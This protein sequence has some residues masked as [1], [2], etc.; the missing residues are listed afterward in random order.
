[1]SR[2][3][4][5]ARQLLSEA[6]ITLNGDQPHDIQIHNESCLRKII[7]G[8]SLALGETYMDGDWDSEQLDTTMTRIMSARL[9]EKVSK[10][11]HLPLLLKTFLINPQSKERAFI[12]GEEHYDIGNDVYECMLDENMVYTCAYW[13]NSVDLSAAQLAKLDL[14]CQKIGLKSGDHVLDIGC[15]WGSFAHYAASRY[16]AKVTGVTVSK[17]QMRLAQ[18]RCAGLDVHFVLQDYRDIQGH[19]VFDH[20]VSLGMFEHVGYK[21][22]RTYMALVHR[23]LKDKGLFLLHTIGNKRKQVK[24][25]PW[26]DKYIFPNGLIPSPAQIASGFDGLFVLEDWHNFGADYDRTLM[27]WYDNFT[28][29]WH[30]LQDRYSERFKRM[31]TFYLLCSAASFRVRDNNQLFQLVLSKNGVAGGYLSKR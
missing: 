1:M 29:R 3:I 13:Q 11:K 30:E 22:Y 27:A 16:G 24:T 26:I 14:V 2:Y 5:F 10:I 6:D 18:Q 20:V 4:D 23:V 8:G 12:V 15:G 7:R 9:E 21:N 19:A 25:D 31:W 17:E 28:R